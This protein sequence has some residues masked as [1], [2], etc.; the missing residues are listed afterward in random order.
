MVIDRVQVGRENQRL[1]SENANRETIKRQ[2][3]SAEMFVYDI[4]LSNRHGNFFLVSFFFA[5]YL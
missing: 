3:T 4:V 5:F 2:L 1:R